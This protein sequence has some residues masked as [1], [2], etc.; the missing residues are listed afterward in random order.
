M[1]LYRNPNFE[2]EE[3][4]PILLTIGTFILWLGWYFFNGGSVYTLYNPNLL[5]SKVITNTIF[6]GYASGVV[7]YFLK[8]PI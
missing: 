7:A 3:E 1:H 8:T 6:S 2:P 4:S 5:P